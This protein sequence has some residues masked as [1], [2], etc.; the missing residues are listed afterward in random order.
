[1]LDAVNGA[2]E[3][4]R[5]LHFTPEHLAVARARIELTRAEFEAAQFDQGQALG[6]EWRHKADDEEL[7]AVPELDHDGVDLW[8]GP[9]AGLAEFAN[10]AVDSRSSIRFVDLTNAFLRGVREGARPD[11]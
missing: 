8:Q 9:L 3:G 5:D 1:M 10:N 2:Q 7:A 4:E 11:S 6:A